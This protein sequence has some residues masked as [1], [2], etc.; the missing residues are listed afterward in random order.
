MNKKDIRWRCVI[1]E[2]FAENSYII[3]GDDSSACVVVDPGF[4]PQKILEQLH[5]EKLVP[6]AILNTHGHSDHI[7]GNAALKEAFP[8][9]ELMIGAGDA[10][11]LLDPWKNL[12]GPFGIELRSPAADR[13][14]REGDVLQLGPL[15]FDVMET[16]GHSIG[17]VV[18]LCRQS[19]PWILIGG[20][21]LFR[22]SI[23][24]TDFPDGEH[25]ELIRV[26]RQKL[27]P[28]PADT[29]VLSGHG[30]P[31]TIEHERIWNPFVGEKA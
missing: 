27:L 16:P 30:E 9:A 4:E 23:G 6:L 17:H 24:R 8:D 1:S 18:F 15:T 19:Q 20:D 28:L 25:Q 3:T 5:E 12:S 29:I 26:I 31:T 22:G 14:L 2:P 13:L 21:V 11:K 10:D 7:A